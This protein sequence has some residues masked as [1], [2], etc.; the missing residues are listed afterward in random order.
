MNRL[1][2]SAVRRAI[3]EA[4]WAIYQARMAEATEAALKKL[5]PDSQASQ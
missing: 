1:I 4:Q 2:Q 3:R 5:A